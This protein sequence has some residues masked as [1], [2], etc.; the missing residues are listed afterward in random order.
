MSD[1]GCTVRRVTDVLATSRVIHFLMPTTTFRR[2]SQAAASIP[3]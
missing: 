3:Q 2:A 1:A